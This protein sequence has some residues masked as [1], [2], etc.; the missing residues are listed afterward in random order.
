VSRPETLRETW[1]QGYFDSMPHDK[2]MARLRMRV[3]DGSV[4]RFIEHWLNAA[5][6]E[7]GGNAKITRKR[8]RQETPQGGVIS[9]LLANMRAPSDPLRVGLP[10]RFIGALCCFDKKKQLWYRI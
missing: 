6:E 3:V 9:L 2:L 1:A 8:N 5:V 10:L 7:K 4:L